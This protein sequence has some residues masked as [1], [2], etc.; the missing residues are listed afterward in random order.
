MSPHPATEPREGTHQLLQL[1]Q[2]LLRDDLLAIA[3]LLRLMDAAHQ[4]EE[5]GRQQGAAE[6][7]HLSMA[8]Q[9]FGAGLNPP[10]LSPLP[11]PITPPEQPPLQWTGLDHVQLDN[12][13]I[14]LQP[15]ACPHPAIFRHARPL[16][17]FPVPGTGAAWPGPSWPKP[18]HSSRPPPHSPSSPYPLSRTISPSLLQIFSSTPAPGSHLT[19]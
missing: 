12:P 11:F 6:Q 15:H 7:A 10:T 2:V 13:T 9:R 1:G 14:V 17:N 3:V 8:E 19:H 4:E 18:G 16:G 5:E